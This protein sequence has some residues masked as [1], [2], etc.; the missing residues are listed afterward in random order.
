MTSKFIVMY[1]NEICEGVFDTLTDAEEY[2]LSIAEEAVYLDF[3]RETTQ[4]Y[5]T[6]WHPGEEAQYG[7]DTPEDWFNQWRLE[8]LEDMWPINDTPRPRQTAY[9]AMLDH[10]ANDEIFEVPYFN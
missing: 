4:G 10:F 6:Y 8:D 3:L 1:D 9:S 2:I 5:V 7:Y